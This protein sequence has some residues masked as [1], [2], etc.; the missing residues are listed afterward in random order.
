M[1]LWEEVTG[2]WPWPLDRCAQ[3][4]PSLLPLYLA[5]L[6]TDTL[7]HPSRTGGLGE[8]PASGEKVM[9]GGHALERMTLGTDSDHDHLQTLPT[10]PLHLC[11]RIS[12]ATAAKD[13]GRGHT[14]LAR[15][16]DQSL[17]SPASRLMFLSPPM[18][19]P[20]DKLQSTVIEIKRWFLCVT[21][22]RQPSESRKI[23]GL[24]KYDNSNNSYHLLI[25]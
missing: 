8:P 24:T 15:S 10:T 16:L 4:S 19:L 13:A 12:E 25:I 11:T 9:K 2:L 20:F 6:I 3:I 22:W 23:K 5:I 14:P 1:T 17:W 18:T 21:V 7:S